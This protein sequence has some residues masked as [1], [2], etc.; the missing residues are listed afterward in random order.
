MFGIFFFLHIR[1]GSHCPDIVIGSLI[2]FLYPGLFVFCAW[3]IDRM[4]VPGTDA[5]SFQ[6]SPSKLRLNCAA[7]AVT[8]RLVDRRGFVCAPFPVEPRSQRTAVTSRFYC[9]PLISGF[10]SILS[11]VLGN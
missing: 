4:A 8:L 3:A 1:W 11:C 5:R 2:V 9:V 7:K 6:V 10:T